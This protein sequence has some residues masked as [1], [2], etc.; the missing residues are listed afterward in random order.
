MLTKKSLLALLL[1]VSLLLAVPAMAEDEDA[2]PYDGSD[3]AAGLSP[4]AGTL[5]RNNIPFQAEYPDNPLIPGQS[6]TTGLPWEGVYA[7]VLEVIDNAH[8][9]HRTGA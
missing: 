3:P 5:K 6:P 4:I 1:A 7:P 2:S 9:A 8:G